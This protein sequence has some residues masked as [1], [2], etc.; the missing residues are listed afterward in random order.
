M[1]KSGGLISARDLADYT[2]LWREPLIAPWR[3]HQLLSTPPP[4]SGGIA[5]TQLLTIR[6]PGSGVRLVSGPR[7][8]DSYNFL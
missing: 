1:E 4:S 2:A 7:A 5:L 3:G 8:P 6:D